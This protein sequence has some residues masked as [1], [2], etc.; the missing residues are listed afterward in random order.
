MVAKFRVE[1]SLQ[2]RLR[3][4]LQEVLVPGERLADVDASED[5]IQRARRL[6]R[7]G[8]LVLLSATLLRPGSILAIATV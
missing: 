5:V 4:P 6:Q 2:G 7:V 1:T 8:R 3:H